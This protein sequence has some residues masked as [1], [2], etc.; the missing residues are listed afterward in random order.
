MTELNISLLHDEP[1]S[2]SLTIPVQGMTCAACALRIERKLNKT[3]GV[4][5]AG[6]NYSSEEAVISRS[7]E[8]PSVKDLVAAIRKTG[9]GVRTSIAETH[10]D[11]EEASIRLEGFLTELEATNGVIDLETVQDAAG[12]KV[13]IGY[14]PTILPGKALSTIITAFR[15]TSA[16]SLTEDIDERGDRERAMRYRLMVAV[17]F[18]TPLAVLAMSHGAI[19]VANGHFVQLLLSLPVVLYSGTPF[20]GAA[21]TALRHRATDMNTLVALGV[22]SAFGYSSVATLAPSL[23]SANGAMP[24]V[25]F[26]AASLIV[27]FV[28]IGR[29]LEERAKG[30]TGEAIALLKNLQ[31]DQ[32]RV[33]RAGVEHM[34][35]VADVELGEQVRILPGERIPVDGFVTEGASPVDEAMVTGESVPVTRRK[36][37]PVIAGTTNTSGVLVVEVSRVGPDTL[38][39]QIAGM[40]SRAQATKAPIQ[41]LAD[42]IAAIFVPSV[43]IVATL[44]GLAWWVLGPEPLLDNALLRFVAVLIIACPCALGL[45][46]PTAIVVGTGRAAR[47]GILIRDAASLQR[48]AVV[49]DVATDK[50]GTVTTG[51]LAV[52]DVRVVE[53][54]DEQELIRLT[55]SVEAWS[56]H[57]LARAILTYSDSL[58]LLPSRASDVSVDPGSGITARV[59]DKLVVVGNQRYVAAATGIEQADDTKIVGSRV[60]VAIDGKYAG[61]IIAADSMRTDAPTMVKRLIRSGRQVHMLTGDNQLTADAVASDAGILAVHAELLPGEKVE[62]IQGLQS[63]GLRVAMIGD[64]INDAPALAIADIGIAVQAGSDIARE[65]SDVTLMRNDLALVPEVFDL[66]SDTMKVIKQNL[67]FAF[68]YNVLLIPIAAGALYPA[69]GILLSPVLASA[70]MALSSISVVT[71]SLRL[72][73]S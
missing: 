41:L 17:L 56:E 48:L 27:T 11:G 30:R 67:F 6:V 46:T 68:V 73:K 38:L 55:A 2:E 59:G 23:V 49:T 42:R 24:D 31:P 47:L 19:D 26:E 65:T 18:S 51:K 5:H 44:T 8:G 53:G 45:A 35:V 22:G 34:V 3:A 64:G 4:E 66:A 52:V 58:D 28:L 57:P 69:F 16:S 50:T 40:V 10:F 72:K 12:V 20:F 25:Y 13:T 39:N 71:N 61:M 37:D 62:V 7:T 14:L 63:K 15:P 1:E 54:V 9:Y 36:G 70:A 32:A 60:L 33:L 29:W 43:L 21:W